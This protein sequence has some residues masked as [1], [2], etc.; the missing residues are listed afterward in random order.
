MDF[1]NEL[2]L[3]SG[4]TAAAFT[5]AA[6]YGFATRVV[7]GSFSA[8]RLNKTIH[9]S[10]LFRNLVGDSTRPESTNLTMK[11]YCIPSIGSSLKSAGRRA[12]GK[13]CRP[14]EGS[15]SSSELAISSYGRFLD[16]ISDSSPA[17][18]RC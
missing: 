17:P 11:R 14:I 5:G 2:A 16:A 10:K 3:S 13:V 4:F 9:Q 6:W 18:S 15:S 12:T 1:G 7:K 8:A